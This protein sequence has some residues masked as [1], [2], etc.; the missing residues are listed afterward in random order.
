MEMVGGVRL[1]GLGGGGGLQ[2]MLGTQIVR[3][4]LLCLS[5]DF[6]TGKYPQVSMKG[7]PVFSGPF[8][9]VFSPLYFF[10]ISPRPV[11]SVLFNFS[12]LLP[13]SPSPSSCFRFPLALSLLSFSPFLSVPSV[14]YLCF[15]FL[16]FVHLLVSV[17][18][19]GFLCFHLLPR[20]CMGFSHQLLGLSLPV[21]LSLVSLSP[22]SSLSLFL[23]ISWP[24]L[25]PKD[26]IFQSPNPIRIGV[27]P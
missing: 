9:L 26:R 21:Y 27:W 4:L 11:T 6:A 1:L 14:S 15:S 7:Q 8:F 18:E 17:E 24:F 10:L 5:S 23:I 20:L 12:C 19:S 25:A 13:I 22:L 16:P 2:E 3:R